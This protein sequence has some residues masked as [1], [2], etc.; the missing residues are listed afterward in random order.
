MAYKNK[1]TEAPFCAFATVHE[2]G[3]AV[4]G[5]QLVVHDS[6][7]QTQEHPRDLNQTLSLSCLQSVTGY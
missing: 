5:F 4:S 2:R 6:I 3:R 1:M 7:E